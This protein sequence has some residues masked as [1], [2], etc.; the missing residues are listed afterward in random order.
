MRLLEFDLSTLLSCPSLNCIIL[1]FCPSI[2]CLSV[3]VRSIECHCFDL[4]NY[5]INV[6]TFLSLIE[7]EL[8]NLP[9][10]ESTTSN[11]SSYLIPPWKKSVICSF[12]H[13]EVSCQPFLN[14]FK[15]STYL[16]R[17]AEIL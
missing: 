16:H 15:G 4:L 12:P 11:I 5:V 10:N 3:L 1:E 2:S 6:R 8:S 17:S 7:Y 9:C 13:Q 14:L